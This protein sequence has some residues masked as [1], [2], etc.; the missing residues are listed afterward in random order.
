MGSKIAAPI[1]DLCRM[2]HATCSQDPFGI[3]LY[4]MM[5]PG[6]MGFFSG[7]FGS[8][9]LFYCLIYPF[10]Y[11]GHIIIG[12]YIVLYISNLFIR[13]Y[14]HRRIQYIFAFSQM[15]L[16]GHDKYNKSY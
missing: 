2:G 4:G 9:W 11:A 5:A 3:I 13:P 1:F 7:S 12:A 10:Y 15:L 16:N 8:R 6:V 14:Y